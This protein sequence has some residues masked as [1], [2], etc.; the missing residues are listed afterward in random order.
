MTRTSF[1]VGALPFA[2]ESAAR[3]DRGKFC[4]GSLVRRDLRDLIDG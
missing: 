1:R 2:Y 4:G 3:P